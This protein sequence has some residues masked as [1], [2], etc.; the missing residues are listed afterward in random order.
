[1]WIGIGLA[2]MFIISR[3]DYHS[4]MDQAPILYLFGVA[5]LLVVLVLGHSRLGAKRW[6]SIG[7]EN[8]QVSELMK[9][10]IIIVLA[11]YFTEVRTDRLT[12]RDFAKVGALTLVPVALILKQPD[13]GT[14]MVLV[15][16]AVVGGFLAGIE[17]KHLLIGAVVV[18]LLVPVGLEHAASFEAV[19]AA[20]HSDVPA[21]GRKSAR[22]GLSDFAV[23]DRGRLRWLL[24]KRIWQGQSEPA[25][26]CAG[27]VFGLH[28]RRA[29][30]GAR[31]HRS[32]RRFASVF[33]FDSA[34]GGQRAESERQGRDVRRDGSDGHFGFPRSGQRIDGDRRIC[35]LPAFRCR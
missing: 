17:W 10:I 19:P 2:G 32:L 30:R 26:L 33:G 11:R 3:I 34:A 15:P 9:L 8:L 1:M 18:A 13:L 4:L 12:L 5:G 25:G 35:R 6:I 14:A 7:G 31:F 24:G 20:A 16:V 29:G 21:P 23:G 27:P 28:S 22:C